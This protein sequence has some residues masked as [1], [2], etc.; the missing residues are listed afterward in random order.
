MNDDRDI[1]LV[2]AAALRYAL[3]RSSYIVPTVQDFLRR[4]LDNEFIK[5][6]KQLYIRDI[7]RHLADNPVTDKYTTESWKQ[8]LADLKN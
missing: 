3:G 2:V 1:A 5:R 6:D 8:L 7:E 4:H